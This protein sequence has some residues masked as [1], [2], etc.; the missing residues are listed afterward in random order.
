MET[1][2]TNECI[3]G[4]PISDDDDYEG[5]ENSDDEPVR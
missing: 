2:P 3:M 1:R 5:W 4:Q